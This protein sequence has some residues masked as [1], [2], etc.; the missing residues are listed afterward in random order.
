[1]S[2]ALPRST[3]RPRPRLVAVSNRV[4]HP[5]GAARGGGLAVALLDALRER[6]GLWFGWSGQIAE[7]PDG[8][9]TETVAGEIRLVTVDLSSSEHEDY[10]NGFANRCLWP[11]FHLRLDLTT[12]DPR[13]YEGYQRVNRRLAYA[14]HPMLQEGDQVWVHDYHLLPFAEALREQRASQP[15]GFF[16]HI[17]FPVPEMLTA[18]PHHRELMRSLFS[19]DLLGFQTEADVQ[20]FRD[21]VCRE[22]GGQLRGNSITAFGRTLTARAFPIGIDAREFAKVAESPAA[23]LEF[24]RVR[25]NRKDRTVIVGVDRL[26]YTKGI[27]E[28]FRSMECLLDRYPDTHGQVELLQIAPTSRGEVPEYMAIRRELEQIA[29]NINGR[30]AQLDWEPIRYINRPLGRRQLAGIYRASQIGLVTPLRDGMNLVA[31]EY[32]A[33][34]NPADPGVLVLSRFAGSAQQMQ[35]AL[36]VNPYD[37]TAVADALQTAR[38]MPLEERRQRHAELMRGLLRD[39]ADAWR[40]SFLEELQRCSLQRAEAGPPTAQA[41]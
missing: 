13:H 22:F 27:P 35:A 2:P 23:R 10:Y 41:A 12:F 26:D 40:E 14:L 33:A 31:K 32:V 25:E 19:Y 3:T 29:G 7:R 17:P 30:Y 38:Y 5:R 34:Q 16:L 4:V 1:M 20:R 15:I 21:C 24:Q 6:G 18:L 28:R 9:A 8:R 39:D 36:I 37:N 11:L